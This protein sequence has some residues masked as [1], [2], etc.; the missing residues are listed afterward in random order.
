MEQ[1][2]FLREAITMYGGACNEFNSESCELVNYHSDPIHHHKALLN[3]VWEKWSVI[4]IG[5]K[6]KF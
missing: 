3:S 5:T 1:T 6:D 2:V 4:V